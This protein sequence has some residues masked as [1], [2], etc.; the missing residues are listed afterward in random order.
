VLRKINHSE[1]ACP[2]FTTLKLDGSLR[3]LADLREVNKVIKR[4]P[5]PLPKITDMLQNL[6]VLCMLYIIGFKYGIL[7]YVANAILQQ[8]MYYCTTMGKV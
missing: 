4:K 8:V 5:F 3:S 2:M 7:P 6:R 1:W